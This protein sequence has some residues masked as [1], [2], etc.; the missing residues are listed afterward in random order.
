[1]KD[2]VNLRIQDLIAKAKELEQNMQQTGVQLQ[3]VSGA[4]QQC[5]WFLAELEKQNA[6]SEVQD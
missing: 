4:I 2:L 1:M 3:Q 5:H 6:S